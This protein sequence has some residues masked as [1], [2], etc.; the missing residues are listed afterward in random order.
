MCLNP[1]QSFQLDVLF[2]TF[3]YLPGYAF[4]AIAC[5]TRS[6]KMLTIMAVAYGAMLIPLQFTEHLSPAD[7]P[8]WF[9]SVIA[10]LVCLWHLAGYLIIAA[11]EDFR[12][13]LN[14]VLLT[15]SIT[16]LLATV[17]HLSLRLASGISF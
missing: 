2:I 7:Y 1:V 8:V 11:T 12:R 17:T 10:G 6:E 14:R 4:L 5:S 3:C 13:M 16:T 15:G 9:V